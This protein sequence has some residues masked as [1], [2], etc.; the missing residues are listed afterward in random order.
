MMS[1][2][3]ILK[4]NA[5]QNEEKSTPLLDLGFIARSYITILRRDKYEW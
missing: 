4:E 1:M 3:L 2:L 5:T